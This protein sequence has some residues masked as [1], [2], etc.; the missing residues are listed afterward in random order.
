MINLESHY[1]YFSDMQLDVSFK[2]NRFFE[3]HIVLSM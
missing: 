2:K 1:A 3:Q